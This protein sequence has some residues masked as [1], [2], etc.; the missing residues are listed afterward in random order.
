MIIYYFPPFSGG[1]VFRSIKFIKYLQR[2]TWEPI[3]LTVKGHS[4]ETIDYTLFNDI[5]KDVSIVRT[6]FI[7]FELFLSILRKLKLG[8]LSALIDR[9]F[10][11][12]DNK[13]GWIPF[14]WHKIKEIFKNYDIDMLYITSPPASI[15]FLGMWIKR[16]YRIPWVIDFRDPWTQN[17]FF[18][19][20]SYIHRLINEFFERRILLSCDWVIANTEGNMIKMKQ[21]YRFLEK[22]I[23]VIT[24]GFD[25]EDFI[26]QREINKNHNFLI[27][28]T[29]TFYWEYSPEYFLRAI[30][31][32]LV[33][34]PLIAS[35]LKILFIGKGINWTLIKNLGLSD[36]IIEIINHVTHRESLSYMCKA[37]LLLLIVP[38]IEG[39][40]S[41]MPGKI[42]E[43]IA[44]G[45]PILATVPEGHAKDLILKT[46]SGVVVHPKD[47]EG[48]KEAIVELYSKDRLSRFVRTKPIPD[49][50]KDYDRAQLTQ[51]LCAHFDLILE[52][53]K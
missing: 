4:I 17:V 11:I 51:K 34:F 23:G 10:L 25:S 24:N 20:I 46:N 9:I 16:R 48:I 14:A 45:R 22:K 12:P 6:K 18:R 49:F 50:I 41:W 2:Y 8:R 47:I 19:P 44:S 30:K 21:K 33:Q 28:Y 52:S 1:G 7:D 42:Y 3:V 13:I 38:D 40:D 35:S 37:D 15:G 53:R 43:Y 39:S 31:K 32:I 26:G 27:A 5:P 36:D 29:G